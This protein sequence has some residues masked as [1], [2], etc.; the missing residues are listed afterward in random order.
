MIVVS[1]RAARMAYS[2]WWLRPGLDVEGILVRQPVGA[3]NFSYL[4]SVQNDI[5]AYQ[6]PYSMG[7]ADAF[8]RNKTVRA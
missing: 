8:P 3:I 4:R 7:I 2:A 5:G 1:N 6:A